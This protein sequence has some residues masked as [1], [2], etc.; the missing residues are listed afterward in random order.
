MRISLYDWCKIHPEKMHLLDQWDYKKMENLHPKMLPMDQERLFI[1]SIRRG[2]HGRLRWLPE[3]PAVV[4]APIAVT[5][6]CWLGTM[7]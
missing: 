6:K 7:I 1:G 4:D 3:Q 5:R 2:T